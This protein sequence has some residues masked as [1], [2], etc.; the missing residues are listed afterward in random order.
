MDYR[1]VW[2]QGSRM[3]KTQPDVELSQATTGSKVTIEEVLQSTIIKS[4][5][6]LSA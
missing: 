2:F 6:R 3:E 4:G 1:K 5:P